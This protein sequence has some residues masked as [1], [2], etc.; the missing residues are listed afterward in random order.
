MRNKLGWIPDLPDYRDYT[1]EDENVFPLLKK[2]E[3]KDDSLPP[4]VD[5]SAWC[6]P[7]EDQGPIGSCTA[8]A[9]VG[10]LEYFEKRAHGKYIDASRRFLYKTTRNLMKLE[11]DTGASIRSTM[12]A[13]ALFGVP[14][15][16]FWPYETNDFDIEP[17]PFCYAFAQCYQAL[18]YFRLDPPRVKG[19]LLLQRIKKRLADGIPLMFGFTVF[20]SIFESDSKGHIPFPALGERIE[21]GHAV[22]AVGY[23]DNMKVKNSYEGALLIRN[24]WGKE[25]GDK[26][27]GWLPYDYVLMGL[28]ED[29]WC[30]IKNE[31]IDTGKFGI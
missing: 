20:S 7:I 30:L 16:E 22:L 9:A 21:G 27:Y 4:S 25:W 8:H 1:E 28:A 11:G 24:S 17:T 19:D 26:G 23:D 13:L 18:K 14:P 3:N 6:S 12:G 29:W 5:L 15:E 2:I 31:W 10:M